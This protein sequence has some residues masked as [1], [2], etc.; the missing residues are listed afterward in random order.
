MKKLF[1][2]IECIAQYESLD[3][4]PQDV[5]QAWRRTAENRYPDIPEHEAYLKY[6]P[7]YAEFGMIACIVGMTTSNIQSSL[8]IGNEYQDRF[9]QEAK[10]LGTF[11]KA[12]DAHAH[13]LIGHRIKAFDIPYLVTRMAAYNLAPSNSLKTYGTKPWELNHILDTY[14]VWKGGLYVSPHS[15]SLEN[16]CRLLGVQSPKADLHGSEVSQAYHTSK[17]QRIEEIVK[18]CE[19]DVT[20]S[21]R[22]YDRLVEL[23]MV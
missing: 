15:A 13:K 21:K 5:Q 1:F 16:V 19:R 4:A 3:L 23:K 20:A 11:K 6:A 17:G 10:I 14:E 12:L 2:D 22:V 9:N 7:L 18:Y 8:S